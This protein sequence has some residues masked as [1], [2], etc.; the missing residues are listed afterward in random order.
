[1]FMTQA[2]TFE[3]RGDLLMSR[4]SLSLTKNIPSRT[5]M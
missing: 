5:R 3:Q 1:M 2:R 4:F